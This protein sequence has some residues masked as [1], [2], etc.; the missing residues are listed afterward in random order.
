[1]STPS[2]HVKMALYADMDIIATSRQTAP[3]VK[4]LKAYLRDLVW[5]LR[6][7]CIASVYWRTPHSLVRLAGTSWTVQFFRKP[8][9]WVDTTHYQRWP[10]KRGWPGRLISGK[11]AA[12]GLGVL[13]PLLNRS[14]LFIWNGVLLVCSSSVQWWTMCF[15]CGHLPPAPIPGGRKCFNLDIAT[16]APWTLVTGKFMRIWDFHSLLTTSNL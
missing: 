4:Y 5:W 16:N 3:L 13:F 2:Q 14:S 10:L 12:Q 9:N 6:E 8:I 15:W 1:M 7:L 11:K